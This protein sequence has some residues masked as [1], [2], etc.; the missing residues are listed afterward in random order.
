M[1]GLYYSMWQQ[2]ATL[3]GWSPD[4]DDDDEGGASQNGRE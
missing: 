2:Q 4:E 3:E 1:G